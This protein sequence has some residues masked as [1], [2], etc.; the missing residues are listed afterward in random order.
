MEEMRRLDR[1]HFRALLLNTKNEVIAREI[2]SIGTLNSS[3]VHPRELFKNAIRRN[4][5]A[6]ILLH[7]HPSGDPTPSQEDLDVTRRLWEA[8]RIIGIEVLDH[9]IIGDNKYVSFKAEG[10]I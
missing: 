7:N 1:E 2:V 4:A 3:T 6:V 8:G 5:A 10:L 9:L